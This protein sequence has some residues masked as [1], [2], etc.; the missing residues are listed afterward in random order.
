MRCALLLF[1]ALALSATTC[2]GAAKVAAPAVP[3]PA[4]RPDAKWT[5]PA[6][7]WRIYGNTW[8][9]GTCGLSSILVT[10]DH[11][12]V[13]IDGDVEEDAALIEANIRALGFRVEDVRYI[14]HSHE[15]HD[16]V[17]GIAKLQHDSHAIVAARA[18]AAAALERGRGDRSDPQFL[19]ATA[20]TP[21]ANVQRIADGE[22]IRVGSNEL[23]AH[24]TP[25]HTPGSTTWTWR[26][27]E[28]QR[29]LD[30]VYA[31]S[32]TAISD[33]VFQY[34]DETA[35]PGYVA[36]FRKS[37]ATIAVLPCDILVTPH[38]DA[39]DL[40]D[41]VGRQPKAALVDQDACRRYA[42]GAADRLDARI[43]KERGKT[44]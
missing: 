41:R 38:P 28:Q 18:P 36:A 12:H 25:G 3:T 26:S 4:S 5:E 20:Y 42:A 31:D 14:L 33:D 11:G 13:L 2:A 21:V 39:S 23:T 19:S 29:C 1:S 15:H 35:H 17:G 6:T 9:V 10:S 34:S 16:H 27:C 24:A 30:I 32:L 43:A 22:T 44:K 8:Y 7:P 40:W 37:I